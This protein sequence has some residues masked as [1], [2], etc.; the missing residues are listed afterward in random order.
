MTPTAPYRSRR[1]PRTGAARAPDEVL[2]LERDVETPDGWDQ[3]AVEVHVLWDRECGPYVDDAFVGGRRTTLTPAEERRAL[4]EAHARA[5]ER[6][7]EA[8]CDHARDR[9]EARTTE[10]WRW[11]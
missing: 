5:D 7:R 11:A 3:V 1:L 2:H 9:A 10:T 4:D 6:R 8:A